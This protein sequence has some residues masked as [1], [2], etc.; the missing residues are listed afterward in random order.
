MAAHWP[1]F[2]FVQRLG[3]NSD[4]QSRRIPMPLTLNTRRV[5]RV[6]VVHCSGR[7]IAG[8]EVDS[9]S[10]HLSELLAEESDFVLHLGNVTFVDSSGL[11]AMV[12]LLASARRKGGDIKLCQVTRE[13]AAV[14][15]LTNLT[16]LFPLHDQEEDAIAA[17]YRQ[18][19]APRQSSR[20]GIRLLCVEH[21]TD[22]LAYVRELL[23]RAG[24]EVLSSTNVPDALLLLRA[25]RPK[26]VVFGPDL[27][28]ATGT[29]QAF[30]QACSTLPVVKLGH[31]F[32]TIDAGKAAAQLLQRIREQLGTDTR[33]ARS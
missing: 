14:L 20:T 19:D 24:F 17:F 10:R 8:I 11:G 27:Q 21:S 6:T 16:Q 13:V 3:A 23:T 12:R 26:V 25:T 5:G 31:E 30:E 28:A 7:I 4:L 32:A 18:A 29:L 33:A 15:K 9:L 22:V 1:P 2:S